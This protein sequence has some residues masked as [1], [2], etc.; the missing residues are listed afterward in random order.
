MDR[1]VGNGIG[2]RDVGK[3]P[4]SKT[5][6]GKIHVHD[7]QGNHR[8][9]VQIKRLIVNFDE[10]QFRNSGISSALKGI[11]KFSS[12]G[13]LHPEV[14]INGHGLLLPVIVCP[15]VVSSGNMI[16]MSMG[17]QQGIQVFYPGT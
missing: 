8:H 9:T 3:G 10:M 12:Q 15:N 6:D 4:H 7:G 2:I 1:G 16:F 13:L 17:E 14:R 11:V 5:L